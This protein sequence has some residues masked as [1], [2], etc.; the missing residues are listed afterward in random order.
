ML[1]F[2]LPLFLLMENQEKRSYGHPFPGQKEKDSVMGREYQG[3]SSEQAEVENP[4][5]ARDL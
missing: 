2:G 1:L 4:Y 5:P 3:D